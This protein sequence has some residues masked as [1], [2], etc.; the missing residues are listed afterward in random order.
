MFTNKIEELKKALPSLMTN[1]PISFEF[2]ASI[3]AIEQEV[4]NSEIT[5]QLAYY[6]IIARFIEAYEES[7][8]RYLARVKLTLAHLNINPEKPLFAVLFSRAKNILPLE[9]IDTIIQKISHL[10]EKDINTTKESDTIKECNRLIAEKLYELQQSTNDL[11]IQTICEESIIGYLIDTPFEEDIRQ[12]MGQLNSITYP[13]TTKNYIF[14][15]MTNKGSNTVFYDKIMLLF[16]SL[17]TLNNLPQRAIIAINQRKIPIETLQFSKDLQR[18]VAYFILMLDKLYKEC[19]HSNE[20]DNLALLLTSV[21][22]LINKSKQMQAKFIFLKK[23]ANLKFFASSNDKK[24]YRKEL[25]KDLDQE[26]KDILEIIQAINNSLKNFPNPKTHPILPATLLALSFLIF[27]ICTFLTLKFVAFISLGVGIGIMAAVA[28]LM[29][30][31]LGWL[32][33]TDSTTS[34]HQYLEPITEYCKRESEVACRKIKEMKDDEE[35]PLQFNNNFQT[36]GLNSKI[37]G[38]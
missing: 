32:I 34:I 16:A 4:N 29:C 11:T 30:L 3:A 13:L 28:T 19:S 8:F 31:S 20:K 7:H 24:I 23:E 37:G 2:K 33:M 26:Q 22:D 12:K 10:E 38:V 18:S 14:Y 35:E 17:N 27:T 21:V 1:L 5:P 6:A 36:S 25:L 9:F 15:Y